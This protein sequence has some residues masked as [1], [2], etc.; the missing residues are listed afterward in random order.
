M[1]KKR[2]RCSRFDASLDDLSSD[3]DERSLFEEEAINV[4]RTGVVIVFFVA[5]SR[6]KRP[7]H[8]RVYCAERS[9]SLCVC[10]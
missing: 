6:K 1:K 3:F 4:S 8:P 7:R 10:A 5:V 2:Q 9:S